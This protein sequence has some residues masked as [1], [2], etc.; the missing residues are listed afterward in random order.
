M[1]NCGNCTHA[2]QSARLGQTEIVGC[3]KLT[4]GEISINDVSGA[5]NLYEGYIYGA[6]RVGDCRE[7][8]DVGLGH[9]VLTL[10]MLCDST[11]TCDRWREVS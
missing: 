5:G 6:R 3:A 8:K 2:R 9:S 10:G 4:L 1:K 7:S 11:M